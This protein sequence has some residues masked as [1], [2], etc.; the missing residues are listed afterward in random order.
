MRWRRKGRWKIQ[1]PF[2]MPVFFVCKK[3]RLPPMIVGDGGH[4]NEQKPI[5]AD[6]NS[7]GTVDVHSIF[8]TIQGEGPYCGERALFIRLY[9]CNLRCPGCDTEYT[10]T[11]NSMTPAEIV[12]HVSA[13]D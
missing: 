7:D 13:L 8:K 3:L 4:M 11:R 9:G 1:R 10:A 2:F 12:N 6:Y 5:A